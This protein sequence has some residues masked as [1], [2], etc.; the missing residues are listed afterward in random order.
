MI[1]REAMRERPEI[2]TRVITL[3]TPVIGGP[4]YT[5]VGAAYRRRGYDLDDIEARPR[6][7]RGRAADGGR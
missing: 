7:P 4:K 1:A 3:G 5:S 6:T 2:V